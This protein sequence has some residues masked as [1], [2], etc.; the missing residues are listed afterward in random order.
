MRFIMTESEA[1][2]KSQNKVQVKTV[3]IFFA[4]RMVEL[5][6]FCVHAFYSINKLYNKIYKLG[7]VKKMAEEK[8]WEIA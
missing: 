3:A 6:D 2:H 5:F 8:W 1:L 4:E 7:E